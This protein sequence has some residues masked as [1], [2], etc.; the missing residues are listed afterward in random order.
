[1]NNNNNNNER[2]AFLDF[3]ASGLNHLSWPI[4]VGWACVD[5]S[6]SSYLIRPH[7][8]WSADAWDPA[9][10][11]LHGISVKQL[12]RDGVPIPDVCDVLDNALS[13][14]RVFVDALSWDEF[15]LFRL[16]EAAGRKASF[17]LYDFAQLIRTII[18]NDQS[19]LCTV[20]KDTARHRAEADAKN[21]R[22]I[23]LAV[24]HSG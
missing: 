21:L 18:G 5:G 22:E 4:E 10:E 19:S 2:I 17:Q 16:Y 14:L 3:E 11:G 8:S 24:K 20:K 23:Y 7:H 13:G 15:W 9:A 12:L 6:S 1:M